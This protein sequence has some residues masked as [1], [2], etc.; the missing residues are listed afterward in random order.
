MDRTI[1]IAENAQ[2]PLTKFKGM[3][4]IPVQTK[5]LNIVN[6]VAHGPSF[7]SFEVSSC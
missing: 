1:H 6:A 5:P 3:Y 4:R 2:P 7:F